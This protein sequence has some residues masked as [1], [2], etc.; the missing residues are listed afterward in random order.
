MCY[1]LLNAQQEVVTSFLNSLEGKKISV[2]SQLVQGLISQYSG[3][4]SK[5]IQEQV[6]VIILTEKGKCIKASRP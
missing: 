2:N 1:K 4:I 5:S 6:E 3:A